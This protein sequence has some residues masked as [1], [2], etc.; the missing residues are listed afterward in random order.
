M[1]YR[2][3]NDV[4]VKDADSLPRIDS[5]LDR[6]TCAKLFSTLDFQAG[7]WQLLEESSKQLTAFK[8][9]YGLNEYSTLP[10]GLCGAPSSFQRVGNDFVKAP[11]G[12]NF[13]FL[14]DIIVLGANL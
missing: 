10:F 13:D 6:S 3:V 9:K 7:Y 1:D 14:D 11:M 2:K 5:C 4:T 8:S 12:G